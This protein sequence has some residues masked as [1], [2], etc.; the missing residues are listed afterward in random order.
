[1]TLLL[2]DNRDSFVFN[3]AQALQIL[4]AEVEVR[5]S[6]AVDPAALRAAPPAALLISPGPGHPREAGNSEACILALHGRVPV[7]GVCL[8]HQAL[9]TALGGRLFRAPPCHGKAWAVEHEGQGLLAGLPSPATFCRYHSLA[10]EKASL[11]EDLAVDAWSPEGL[12]M[13]VRHRQ[14]PSYGVQFHP[15]SFRSPQGL[16]L[17]RNFLALIPS[18]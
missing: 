8:G 3:L 16:D 10:V 9:C 18:P 6:D 12:I 1:M 17:L 5:R 2:L 13:A 15:E 7:L 14:A 4:G 11:P